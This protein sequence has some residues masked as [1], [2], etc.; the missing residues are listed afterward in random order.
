MPVAKKDLLYKMATHLPLFQNFSPARFP[1]TL[2]R[3]SLLI[4]FIQFIFILL[5]LLPFPFAIPSSPFAITAIAMGVLLGL[6]TLVYNRIGN[7]NIRPEPKP[8]AKLV[9]DGPYRLV[10]HP[11]YDAVLL[12]MA[13]WAFF[14]DDAAKPF[15]WLG[16]L[17]VLWVKSSI[18]EKMLILKYPDYIDYMR[19]T[20]RLLP[21]WSSLFASKKSRG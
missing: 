7:F 12:V 10:R 13:A 11:M 1:D 14:A 19:S 18:E 3:M 21:R 20:G 15:Y 2:S 8:N 5:L 4:V 6:W 16:L 17:H 9:T